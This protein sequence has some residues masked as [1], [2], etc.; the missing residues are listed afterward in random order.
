MNECMSRLIC[1]GG[2]IFNGIFEIR[3]RKSL[4]KICFGLRL[5]LHHHKNTEYEEMF[6]AQL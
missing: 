2:E 6:G 4:T 1:T 3:A 5:I